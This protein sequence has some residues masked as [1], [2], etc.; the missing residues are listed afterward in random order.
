MPVAILGC[1]ITSSPSG[2]SLYGCGTRSIG[3]RQSRRCFPSV[4]SV[5]L[6]EHEKPDRHCAANTFE[7]APDRSPGNLREQH[8]EHAR[9]VPGPMPGVNRPGFRAHFLSWERRRALR[10]RHG[11]GNRV[12]IS[13]LSG[14]GEST[15]GGCVSRSTPIFLWCREPVWERGGRGRT[16]SG[17]FAGTVD[18]CFEH[19]YLTFA[20]TQR[21]RRRPVRSRGICRGRVELRQLR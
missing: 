11:M 1:A 20:V 10:A 8:P 13:P 3:P 9:G 12:P 15:I 19:V 2:L 7:T 6:P 5:A 4:S 21:L 18:C 17:P 14:V 16:V